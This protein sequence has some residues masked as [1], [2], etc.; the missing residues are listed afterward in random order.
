MKYYKG[1]QSMDKEKTKYESNVLLWS[2][3]PKSMNKW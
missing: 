1:P 2:A 3:V